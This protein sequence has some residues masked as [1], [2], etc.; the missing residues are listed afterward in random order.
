MDKLTIEHERDEMWAWPKGMG[1]KEYGDFAAGV[2]RG[3]EPHGDG[4][5]HGT[6]IARGLLDGVPF[7]E[8]KWSWIE[9]AG[10]ERKSDEAL[11]AVWR[12]LDDK[13]R[14]RAGALMAEGIV[15]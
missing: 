6:L 12:Q 2:T 11:A 13:L 7:G 1:D 5:W 15:T 3:R 9:R 10:D 14:R 4:R 8:E